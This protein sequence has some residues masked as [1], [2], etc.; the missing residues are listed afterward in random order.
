MEKAIDAEGE[1]GQVGRRRQD[2]VAA[3]VDH[4][5]GS[6]QNQDM[7]YIRERWK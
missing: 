2:D 5:D 4:V 7:L 6:N 1:K 3:A